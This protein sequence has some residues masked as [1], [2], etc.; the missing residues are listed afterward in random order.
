[1]TLALEMKMG[2]ISEHDSGGSQWV[3]GQTKGQMMNPTMGRVKWCKVGGCGTH[4]VV[5][6]PPQS[7]G[8]G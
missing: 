6:T 4:W 1:M 2:Q 7:G 5:R 8:D 3:G